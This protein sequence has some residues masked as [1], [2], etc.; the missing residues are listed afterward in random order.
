MYLVAAACFIFGLYSAALG[1][2]SYFIYAMAAGV[3][4]VGARYF[5]GSFGNTE[6]HSR[7]GYAFEILIFIIVAIFGIDEIF[8]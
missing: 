1:D 8:G 4:L 3:V 5:F 2:D 6:L 7:T